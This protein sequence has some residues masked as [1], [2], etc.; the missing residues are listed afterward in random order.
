MICDECHEREAVIS[1]TEIVNGVRS[2]RHLC[3]V[4]AA[5]KTALEPSI[6]AF[7]N[8]SFLGNLLASVLGLTQDKDTP[9]NLKKTNLV[10]PTCHMTYNEFLKFGTFGCP[11]CYRTFNFLLDGYFKKIHGNFEHTGKHPAA[12]GE[13]VHVVQLDPA[14]FEESAG[15]AVE[16]DRD[17]AITVDDPS[18]EEELR[19]ALNRAVAREEYEEAARIRDIIRAM[20]GSQR[21]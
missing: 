15:Q 2:E 8:T 9:E 18:S 11:D 12:H 16:K 6:T 21:V 7:A 3:S 14:A 20:K 1:I 4:C 13:T 5:R 17:I 10:C 19:A